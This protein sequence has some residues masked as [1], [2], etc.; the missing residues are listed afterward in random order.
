MTGGRS[1]V[2]VSSLADGHLQTVAASGLVW[3]SSTTRTIK[4]RMSVT[5]PVILTAG[6]QLSG[7]RIDQ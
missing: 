5:S 6:S 2:S 1:L 4:L 3:L 7:V